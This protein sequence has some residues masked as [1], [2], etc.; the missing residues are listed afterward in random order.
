MKLSGFFAQGI[1][2]GI[3]ATTAWSQSTAS[4]SG[5]VTDPTGA[6]VPGAE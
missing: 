2:V 6:V 1:L 4:I 5:T 3:L